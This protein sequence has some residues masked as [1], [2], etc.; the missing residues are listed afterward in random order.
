MPEYQLNMYNTNNHRDGHCLSYHSRMNYDYFINAHYETVDVEHIMSYCFRSAEENNSM[1]IFDFQNSTDPGFTF[2][3]LKQKNIT[4]QM[5]LSWSASIDMAERYQIFLNNH[6]NSS[7]EKDVIFY[8]CTSSWFVSFCQCTLDYEM[9]KSVSFSDFVYFIFR[10]KSPLRKELFN[11]TFAN[12][13]LL[14]RI[15]YYHISCQKQPE[16]VCF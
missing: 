4:S 10:Y 7:S 13:H 14:K 15:K 8:N 16:L 6:S 9:D 1:V 11:E 2:A 3:K 12:Q 5:L